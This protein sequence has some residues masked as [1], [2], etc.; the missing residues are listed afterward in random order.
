MKKYRSLTIN[1]KN[2]KHSVLVCTNN[3]RDIKKNEV[4]VKIKYSSLNYKDALSVTGK[5][6]IIR[7]EKMIP[8]LD[9]SGIVVESSSKKFIKGEKVL[10]TGSGLGETINGGFSEYAYVP[11]NILINI[12][13]NLTLL[14]TMQIGTAGFTAAISIEKMLLNKQKSSSGPIVITGAS[15]GVGSHCINILNNLGFN[16]IAVT[17]NKK[18]ASYLKDIGASKVTMYPDKMI[19]KPLNKQLFAGAIDNVGG[20]ILDWVLKST[21]ENGNIVSVGMASSH[22]LNT[23]VFPLIMRGVNI[24]GVS[25][26]NYPNKDRNKVWGNLSKKYKPTKLRK[27]NKNYISLEEVIKFSEDLIYGKNFGRTILKIS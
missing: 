12:P 21:K 8:G 22:E 25:S 4:L 10:A 11:D 2:D 18:S 1:Y 7:G 23:T 16:T 24:L 27:I 20:E 13:E 6:K 5:S 9:F 14:S 3:F 19:K 17:R 26:T 15:G